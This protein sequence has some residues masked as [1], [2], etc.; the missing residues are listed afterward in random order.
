MF[1][2]QLLKGCHREPVTDVTGV[3][4]PLKLA[5]CCLK[6]MGIATPVCGL[7]RNDT[8]FYTVFTARQTEI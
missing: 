8:F 5:V 3:A 2:G 7:A 6:S 4:T 1:I